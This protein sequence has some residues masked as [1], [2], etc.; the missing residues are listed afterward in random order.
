MDQIL[1]D[2]TG[3]AVQ[4]GSEVVVIGTQGKESITVQEIADQAGT[5]PWEVL[6]GITP[7]VVRRVLGSE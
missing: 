2:V 7:R 6:T 5:I 1:V 3:A 4:P